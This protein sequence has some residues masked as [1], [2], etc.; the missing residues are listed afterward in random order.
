MTLNSLVVRGQ[1]AKCATL[2]E[3]HL[4]EACRDLRCPRLRTVQGQLPKASYL[5]LKETTRVLGSSHGEHL[6]EVTKVHGSSHGKHLRGGHLSTRFISWRTSQ[7]GHSSMR[8]ISR[9][10]PEYMAYLMK[11]ISGEVAQVLGSS[12]GGHLRG[13]RPSTG[14]ISWRTSQGGC[15]ST[16]LISLRTS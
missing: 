9:R 4:R 2:P 11:N 14:L 7:G 3:E 1:R 6:K 8:F 10:S 13:G 16:G 12:H 5:L 15:L